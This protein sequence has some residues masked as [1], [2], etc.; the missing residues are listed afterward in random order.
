MND[1]I[2]QFKEYISQ[3]SFEYIPFKVLGFPILSPLEACCY[4]GSVN[5]FNFIISNYKQKITQECLKYSLIGGNT[6][7][8]NESLKNNTI[9]KECFVCI[10]ASHNNQ[11]LDY[12]FERN[13]FNLDISDFAE[14][15]FSQNIK[16]A[17]LMFEKNKDSILPWCAA[18]PQTLEIFKNEDLDFTK[19]SI[20]NETILIVAMIYNNTEI[21][22]FLID[23][24]KDKALDINAQDN[25]KFSA[26]C[27]A[28]K[29]NNKEIAELLISHGA[30]VDAAD[31]YGEVPLNIA[32]QNN[33]QDLI[34]LLIS[35]KADLNACNKNKITAL[36][37]A[38]ENNNIE[39]MNL[40]FSHGANVDPK[41]E[42]GKTPLHIA[43]D[44]NFKEAAEI[45]ISH[46][47]AINI[48]FLGG[49]TPL[50]VAA[51]KNSK[52]TAEVLL[53]HGAKINKQI[54]GQYD[55]LYQAIS[56]NCYETAELLISHGA[57]INSKNNI[58]GK[59][60]LQYEL[61]LNNF[62]SIEFL[63]SHGVDINAREH[64]NRD[65]AL[66]IAVRK[67]SEKAIEL[68]LSHGAK[69]DL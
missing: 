9:D 61:D 4:F 28:V 6:D 17:F 21:C 7:I 10:A 41:D 67:N 57:N 50:H 22:K 64:F 19:K 59:T 29:N 11:F 20:R 32:V 62:E 3:H 18:F 39:I 16:V 2:D 56:N 45:L 49:E 52:E 65:T 5:I 30:K 15:I 26:L 25:D 38:V 14:I 47:A 54:H 53:I 34:E 48:R 12:I 23:S 8:I 44:K 37:V 51:R 66:H 69:I 55:P 33:N 35:N 46:G 31:D 42:N 43:A 24:L 13:L 40:L 1:K 27:Y 60:R 58:S 63:L 68:L 36:H